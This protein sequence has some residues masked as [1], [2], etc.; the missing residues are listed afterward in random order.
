MGPLEGFLAT[1]SQAR[2]TFGRGLPADGSQFDSSAV[3]RRLQAEVQSAAP[4]DLWRGDAATAYAAANTE[5]AQM[6]GKLG[7]LDARLAA[8]IDK[9]ARVVTV[10][11]AQLDSLREW[12]ITAASS[13]PANQAGQLMLTVSSGLGRLRAIL[14]ES[15][16]ELNAIGAQIRQIGA[17]YLLL[18]QQDI[19]P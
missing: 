16:A 8:E 12:V 1:W 19:A 13:V 14:S 4:G 18:N 2:Q 15:N 5:Q 3:L 6:F 17:E 10:G 7:D 11:R 9:S